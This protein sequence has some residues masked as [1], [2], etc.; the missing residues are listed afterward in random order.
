MNAWVEVD[1][2]AAAKMI[3]SIDG[4]YYNGRQIRMNDADSGG[5]RKT[6]REGRKRI[7]LRERR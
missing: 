3:K 7:P 1:Q 5:P 4:K 6:G 2:A